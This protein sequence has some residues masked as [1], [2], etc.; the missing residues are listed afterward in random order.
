[1]RTVSFIFRSSLTICLLMILFSTTYAQ[2]TVQCNSC[3]GTGTYAGSTAYCNTIQIP[4][5]FIPVNSN[6]PWE[7]IYEEEFDDP[8][9]HFD[10]EWDSPYNMTQEPTAYNNYDDAYL[11]SCIRRNNLEFGSSVIGTNTETWVNLKTKYEPGSVCDWVE[12]DAN[13]QPI[14]HQTT[15]D[16]TLPQLN[17]KA[18]YGPGKFEIHCKVPQISGQWPAFWLYENDGGVHTGQEIDV[19]EI[20][21]DAM[22]ANCSIDPNCTNPEYT[23][24]SQAGKRMM[25]TTHSNPL[26]LA[27]PCTPQ[28][29]YINSEPF[30]NGWHTF[31]LVWDEN[32]MQWFMDGNLVFER[33]R[34]SYYSPGNYT[35]KELTFPSPKIGMEIKIGSIVW[36]DENM[37]YINGSGQNICGS[38]IAPNDFL[39]DYVRV[40][41]RGCNN[42]PRTLK[43]DYDP[44]TFYDANDAIVQAGTIDFSAT[45]PAWEVNS[46]Q[47]LKVGAINEIKIVNFEAKLGCDFTATI[48]NCDELVYG[49]KAEAG[50]ESSEIKQEKTT[51]L[52]S[53]SPNP[54]STTIKLKSQS[55]VRKANIEIFD[56]LGKRVFF[57]NQEILKDTELNI[58]SLNQGVYLLRISNDAGFLETH[59]IVK[60]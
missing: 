58:T 57:V 8:D 30:S 19:F 14:V 13:L 38:P 59:Q 32:Y 47:V 46:N 44:I 35:Y 41:K 55:I 51:P 11:Y 49:R 16:Y 3:A 33:T 7:L 9:L 24:V 6:A 25:M 22:H 5:Q 39:V 36:T 21:Q 43:Y 53:I 60:N 12:F 52:F 29:C 26:L 40:W 45:S 28:M 4:G 23:T 1:M 56:M 50:D 15:R 54:S 34:M 18:I 48:N 42:Q 2:V 17:T 20:K 10:V 37:L 31:T 27:E